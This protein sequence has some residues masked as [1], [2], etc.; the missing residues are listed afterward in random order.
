MAG[1]DL[2]KGINYWRETGDGM[3][4][5]LADTVE[6]AGELPEE[7]ELIDLLT[8]YFV[9]SMGC[10]EMKLNNEAE[11][12]NTR[13]ANFMLGLGKMGL[14]PGKYKNP[15]TNF[16]FNGLYDRVVSISSSQAAY[17][18]LESNRFGPEVWVEG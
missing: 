6:E 16:K 2:I 5:Q 17:L 15:I 1:I 11:S 18:M 8:F 7:S 13:A 10:R 4:I 12:F 3:L 9:F 14:Q